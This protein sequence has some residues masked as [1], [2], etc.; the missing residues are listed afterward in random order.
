VNH[1]A[2]EDELRRELGAL[3]PEARKAFALHGAEQIVRL[4]SRNGAADPPRQELTDRLDSGWRQ[5]LEGGR[6]DSDNL[7]RLVPDEDDEWNTEI[8]LRGNAVLAVISALRC[9]EDGRT[10]HCLQVVSQAAEAAEL[11]D[12]QQVDGSEFTERVEQEL[13]DGE[14]AR[15]QRQAQDQA[16]ALLGRGDSDSGQALMEVV[17]ELRGS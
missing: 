15:R 10:D 3:S 17:E 1:E 16:L 5:L 11:V 6:V 14:Q 8:G 2:R 12:G 13:W 4:W 9:L 7:E